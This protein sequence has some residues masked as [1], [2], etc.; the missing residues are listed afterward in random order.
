V[1][2]SVRVVPHAENDRLIGVK[3]YGVRRRSVL[4]KLGLHNG[5]LLRAVN[6]LAVASPDAAL[7]AYA[8]LR[9]TSRL[10]VSVERRGQPMTLS[11]LID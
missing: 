5:D 9:G 6:G 1:L 3:L 4:G 2:P 11:Y 10:S 7:Q 8:Q